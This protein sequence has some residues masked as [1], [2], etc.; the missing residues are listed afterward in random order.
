MKRA[1]AYYRVSTWDQTIENQRAAVRPLVEGRGWRLVHEVEETASG[2][3]QRKGWKTIIDDARRRRID[4]VAVWSLDRVG[5]SLWSISD[6]VR[7][8]DALGVKLVSV[9]E[10]WLDLPDGAGELAELLRA[11]M[12]SMFDFVAAFERRRLI[13]RT[14]AGHATAR[15]NGKTI[16][17][18]RVLAGPALAAA[19]EARLKKPPESWGAIRELLRTQHGKKLTKGTIQTA[20]TRAIAAVQAS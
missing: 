20:V 15:R 2:A 16:G 13:D 18:P 4:V 11:H 6:A 17:R 3:K 14:L 10:P 19:I 5:R 1:A 12:V 7:E 8:L 9:Q